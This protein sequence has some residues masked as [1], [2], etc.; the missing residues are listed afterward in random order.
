[1]KIRLST[2]LIMTSTISLYIS[3]MTQRQRERERSHSGIPL[4]SYSMLKLCWRKIIPVSTLEAAWRP[5]GISR[6]LLVMAAGRGMSSDPELWWEK[7]WK[8]KYQEGVGVGA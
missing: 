8:A 5:V 6:R 4:L 2:E 7:A 1:M 3:E